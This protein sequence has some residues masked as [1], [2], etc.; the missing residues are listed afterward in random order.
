ML[1]QALTEL[2]P[3]FDQRYSRIGRFSV[4]PEKLLIGLLRQ[5]LFSIRCVR[6]LMDQFGYN[7]LY[8]WFLGHAM[9]DKVWGYSA[10]AQNQDRLIDTDVARKFIE[11]M[12][13]R[14]EQAD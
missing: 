5:T 2:S 1:D 10:F 12:Q 6:Q 11:R 8:K 14:A 4:P 13:A 7:V 3:E 9:E